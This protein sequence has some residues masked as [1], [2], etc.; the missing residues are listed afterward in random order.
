M[1]TILDYVKYYK[2]SSLKKINFNMMDQLVCALLSYLPVKSF[3]REKNLE[4]VLE[5]SIKGKDAKTLKGFNKDIY[6][7][8]KAMISSRRYRDMTLTNFAKIKNEKTQLEL[9]Q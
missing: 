7:F 1:F 8:A 9:L 6:D 3:K 4:E 2:A 5:E